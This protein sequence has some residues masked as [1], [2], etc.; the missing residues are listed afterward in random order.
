MKWKNVAKGEAAAQKRKDLAESKWV[1]NKKLAQAKLLKTSSVKLEK[2]T[3]ATEN[4][5][6]AL[7]RQEEMKIETAEK[8]RLR[9]EL[10]ATDVKQNAVALRK[11]AAAIKKKR[12]ANTNLLDNHKSEPLAQSLYPSSLPFIPSK[13]TNSPQKKLLQPSLFSNLILQPTPFIET[14]V[15]WRTRVKMETWRRKSISWGGFSLVGKRTN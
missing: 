11:Q 4:K 13:T 14:N 3:R 10:K 6:I 2:E 12:R 9:A 7:A 8:H 5:I 15:D 1:R